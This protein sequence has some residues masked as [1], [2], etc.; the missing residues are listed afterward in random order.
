MGQ[1]RDIALVFEGSGHEGKLVGGL[2]LVVGGEKAKQILVL[3]NN[4]YAFIWLLPTTNQ[5]LPTNNYQPFL[6]R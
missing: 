2:S 4:G 5:Q 6:M 1:N 3:E